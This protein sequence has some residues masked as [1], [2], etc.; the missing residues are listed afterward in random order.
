MVFIM[1]GNAPLQASSDGYYETILQGYKAF[2]LDEK[3]LENALQKS[4]D[5]GYNEDFQLKF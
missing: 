4:I 3:Y 1:N 2:G 5:F